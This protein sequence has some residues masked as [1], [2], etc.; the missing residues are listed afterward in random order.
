MPI[1]H[2]HSNY[3]D[4]PANHTGQDPAHMGQDLDKMFGGMPP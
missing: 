3:A 2:G 1:F 4:G